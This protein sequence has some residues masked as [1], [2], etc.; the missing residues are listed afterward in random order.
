MATLFK[1]A[2]VLNKNFD[3]NE[4]YDVFVDENRISKID[5]NLNQDELFEGAKDGKENKVIDCNG[6]YLIP[7]FKNAHTHNAMVFIRSLSDDL[8]L[9]KWLEKYCFPNEAKLTYEDIYYFTVLGIMENLSSGVTGSMDMYLDNYAVADASLKTGFRITLCDTL[10][11][12]N[13]KIA[14]EEYYLNLNNYKNDNGNFVRY[15][16]GMHAEYTNTKETLKL[17]S[18][19]THKYKAT[20]FTH[21]SETKKEFDECKERWGGLTPTQVFE[22]YGLFDYGGGCY[23][24][25]W[26]DDKDI[27]IFKKHNLIAVT[28]PGSNV[29]LASGIPPVKKFLDKGMRVAIG[30]DGPASNNAIDIFREMYLTTTLQKVTERDP[31]ILNPKEI[32][33]MVFVN[34]ASCLFHEDADCIEEG[35]L[36]DLVLIDVNRPNMQPLN[37]FINNLVYAAD[38]TNV[39][40]TMIDGV[41]RY[42]DGKFN[43]GEDEN[44]VYKK[45]NELLKN[46]LNR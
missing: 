16:L 37:T 35:K 36:A 23:H 43:I 8:T 12:F 4:G 20:F 33:N 46:L 5:K 11:K 34:G 22:E 2:N 24:C 26:I 19:L 44:Y 31:A 30:T 32:L 27:E 13:K 18:D 45:C 40:M 14:P 9:D 3:I 39:K 21:N 6:N 7:G 38:K 10:Q 28:C 17:V 42:M 25:V 41:I 29:K 15:T 1:N